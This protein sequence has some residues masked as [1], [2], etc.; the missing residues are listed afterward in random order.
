[1]EIENRSYLL[2]RQLELKKKQLNLK[3]KDNL[4]YFL[5]ATMPTYERQWFH[6]LIANKCQELFEGKIQKMMLFVPPQHGK[7]I[8]DSQI[9]YTPNGV[10]THGKLKV[11]DFVFGRNGKP[12]IVQ[13]VSEK[14]QSEYIVTFSDGSKVE[15]HGNHEWVVFDRNK[16]RE[17]IVETKDLKNIESGIP[18]KRGHRYR[19]MIDTFPCIEFPERSVLIDPYTLGVW[20]GDG[21]S[22]DPVIHIGNNDT[23]IINA[24]PYEVEEGIGTTTRIFYIHKQRA[25]FTA[26]NL[27]ENKHI[28][29]DYIYNS[30]EVRKQLVAG[31]IDTDGYVYDKNGRVTI[32]NANE[33]VI[34]SVAFILRSLGQSVSISE[35][36]PRL[37]SSGIQGK[38]IVYQLCFNP[39]MDFPTKVPRK[40]INRVVANRRRSIISV[41]RH[42]NLGYGNCI[43]VEGGVY[44][45]G[46]TFIPTHNSE[47]ASRK[48]P[49]W[50]LGRNPRTKIAG[51]SYSADLAGGFSRS[52]QL[53]LDSDEYEDIF[54]E[55]VIPSRGGGG[56]IRNV[57]YFDTLK[58]GFYKAVGVTGGL[59]G[60]PVD[61][62]IIDDPVKDKIEAYSETYRNR[63]WDWY[64]DVLLTRLHNN[65]KI[66][67]IMTRWHDDDLAGRILKAESGWEVVYLPAIKEDNTNKH[68]PREIGEPLWGDKHSLARLREMEKRSPRTFAALYQQH[69]SI[70]GG[71]IWH[72][73]W[74][75]II[76]QSQFLGIKHRDI[77]IHFF[78]DTAY[79][80]KK[81]GNDPS[82]ILAACRIGNN[83]YITDAKSVFKQFP[84]L[85]K[86][87]PDH[88]KA[89]GYTNSSTL[90]VEPK[91]N[92]KSVV[93]QLK[94]ETDLNVTETPSPTESKEVRANA[95]SAKI[96]CGRVV[97][98]EG[99]WNSEYLHQVTQFPAVAH[100]EYVDL[101]NYA[102]DYLINDEI[103]IPDNIE[104]LLGI[105][106]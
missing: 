49:A 84:D 34:N 104:E 54:G 86:F 53:T 63:V 11:G 42:D 28:P 50:V 29:D 27:L 1:M 14:T 19:Y 98:V 5:N 6:E 71:N 69:P 83:M 103:V 99:E 37:S 91:A 70:E 51:A 22:A 88:V 68:D 66:L 48:F 59:T 8:S 52:V 17:R 105:E 20:I 61:L 45:I 10:T 82:G 15:C 76:T 26:Y 30:I 31:I 16:H 7:Q 33:G 4:A 87:L 36:E 75:P 101:T 3:A 46:E 95:N 96:E 77:H 102:I 80:E 64:T 38:Q 56:L 40:K 74:F 62:A 32:S 39:T 65:S 79:D 90:R 23:E 43:Q 57:D 94:R 72:K 55:K 89:K 25:K 73:E 92:G 41:E 13:A 35:F 100:D 12:T 106:Y 47:I 93:Q 85:I 81:S 78:L 9:I 44:L 18:G 21:K 2:R 24:I 67:L 58:G 97:L 60:T